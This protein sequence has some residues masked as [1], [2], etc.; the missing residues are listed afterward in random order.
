MKSRQRR[1][2]RCGQKAVRQHKQITAEGCS[3]QSNE[4]DHQREICPLDETD[5]KEVQPAVRAGG[6]KQRWSVGNI[7]ELNQTNFRQKSV[8]VGAF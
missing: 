6:L 8:S 7:I 5:S 4:S 3:K 1:Q 2:N